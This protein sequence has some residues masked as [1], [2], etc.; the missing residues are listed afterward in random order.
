MS[1]KLDMTFPIFQVTANNFDGHATENQQL[2]Y[3]DGIS[4]DSN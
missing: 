2:G 3:W 4:G 1:C